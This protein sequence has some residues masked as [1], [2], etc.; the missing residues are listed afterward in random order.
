MT[1]IELQE[2]LRNRFPQE[3]ESCDWKEYK[4][5]KNQFNGNEGDD[6]VSYGGCCKMLFMP[7]R[8]NAYNSQM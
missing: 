4:T 8:N 5:L 6:V 1:E 7:F 3:N 2:C